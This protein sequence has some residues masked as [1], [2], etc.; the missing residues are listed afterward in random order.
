MAVTGEAMVMVEI[1]YEKREDGFYVVI[2][3]AGRGGWQL[4]PYATREEA[5]A[6]SEVV[7]NELRAAEGAIAVPGGKPN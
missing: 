5:A 6:L 4:G 7:G 3:P 1:G 2:E